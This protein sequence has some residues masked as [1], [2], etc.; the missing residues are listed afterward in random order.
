MSPL[1]TPGPVDVAP[2]VLAAQARPML[3]QDSRTLEG[4]F[5][6]TA[7]KAHRLFKTQ[8]RVLQSSGTGSAMQ[9]AGLRSL[10]QSKVLCCL[11]GAFSER[12]LAIAEANGEAS[13]PPRSGLGPA[14]PA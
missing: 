8:G 5:A 6:R 4:L 12:W 13:R 3:A 2:E 14:H 1:F 7:E 10:V 11:N 9:E